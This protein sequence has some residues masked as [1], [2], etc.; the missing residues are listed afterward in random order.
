M[1]R[2]RC[3][4]LFSATALPLGVAAAPNFFPCSSVIFR[5]QTLYIVLQFCYLHFHW[6]ERDPLKININSKPSRCGDFMS[7]LG[8]LS[9]QN[10]DTRSF[11]CE[12]AKIQVRYFFKKKNFVKS[13]RKQYGN[14]DSHPFL[15]TRPP[16]IFFSEFCWKLRNF[17]W[18][19][20][21]SR[22]Q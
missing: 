10:H 2:A 19:V 3:G 17:T 13:V 15:F 7:S 5:I 4:L 11:L 21:E 6:R 16:H 20:A 22:W 14:L 9:N 12:E 18:R 1:H 8:F